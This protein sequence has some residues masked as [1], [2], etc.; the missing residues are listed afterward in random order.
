MKTQKN[1]RNKLTIS[2]LKELLIYNPD[3]GN[4]YWKKGT[5]RVGKGY[6]AGT[7]IEAGYIHIQID[8]KLYNGSR[9]A[10]FYVHGYFSENEID[11]IDRIRSNNAI[12]NLREVSHSCNLQNSGNRKDTTTGVKGVN[13]NKRSKKFIALIHVNKIRYYLGCFDNKLDAAIARHN[14]EINLDYG[15]CN[16]FDSPAY[17][18]IQ[19]NL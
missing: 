12:N 14:G 6:V 19:A 13:Y 16:T 5:G 9:L 7:K 15:K 11:H 2:R 17:S 18:Y 8:E 3:N 4:F 10:W 1:G